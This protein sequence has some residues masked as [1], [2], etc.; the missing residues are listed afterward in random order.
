MNDNNHEIDEEPLAYQIL[1]L[2]DLI[3]EIVKCCEDRKLYESQKF[4][5]PY[6]ELNLLMQ[7][8]EERYLTAKGISKKLEVAKSRVTKIVNGLIE[9]SL[10]EQINDPMDARI[11][12]ISLTASGKKKAGEIDVFLKKLHRQILLQL[13]PEER[14]KMISYLQM[15][16]SAME[17]VKA[18]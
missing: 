12:L 18:Q 14:K 17:T 1:S 7:F 6:A 11:K 8:D 5:L 2:K 10:V 15:L 13:I 16:R 9:K 4:G 3:Q